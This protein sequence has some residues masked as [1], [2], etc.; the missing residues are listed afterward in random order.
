MKRRAFFT[1]GAALLTLPYSKLT[2]AEQRR[3]LYIATPGIRNYVS[4]GGVGILVYDI[5]DG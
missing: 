2:T 5:S 1:A 3:R 4:Y